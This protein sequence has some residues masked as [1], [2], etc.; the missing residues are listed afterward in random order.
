MKVPKSEIIS[1]IVMSLEETY[2]LK[3]L[4]FSKQVNISNYML[5]H[6]LR[7]MNHYNI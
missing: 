5:K 1:L 2:E 3:Y 6:Y 7:E 4:N